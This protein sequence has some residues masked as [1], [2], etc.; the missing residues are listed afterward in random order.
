MNGLNPDDVIALK[1]ITKKRMLNTTIRVILLLLCSSEKSLSCQR[2]I[3]LNPPQK[4][5]KTA[6]MSMV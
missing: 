2:S 6:T 1:L 4:E 5:K 3:D